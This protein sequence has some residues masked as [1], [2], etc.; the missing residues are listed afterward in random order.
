MICGGGLI[1]SVRIE[2]SSRSDSVVRDEFDS[3]FVLLPDQIKTKTKSKNF[4]P[5][6]GLWKLL[7]NYGANRNCEFWLARSSDT[8]EIIARIGA[9]IPRDRISECS[10]GFFECV[11]STD[12]RLA[13]KELIRTAVRWLAERN[14][15]AIVAPMDFNSWFS[16]RFKVRQ[17]AASTNGDDK[18]WEP[19][20]PDFHLSLF[21]DEGFDDFIQF[22][23]LSYEIA[24]PEHW[25]AY[26]RKIQPDYQAAIGQGYILRPFGTG[27]E[28][29]SDLREIFSLANIA[30]ADNPM[31]EPIPFELFSS[32]T[33]ASSQKSNMEAS[34]ICKS[35]EGQVAGFAFCFTEKDELVY[36]T[37]AV[38]PDHRSKGLAN[39]LTFEISNY[40]QEKGIRKTTGAL[41]RS[42]NRSE[43]IGQAH[44]QFA[45]PS[46][47]NSYVLLR[48]TVK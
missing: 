25:A 8:G 2:I 41:I 38:H 43:R 11:D 28:F 12:G 18:S 13:G 9:D 44:G 4:T 35:S 33:I 48:R 30:F 14:A 22:A 5:T 47:I 15:Q 26:I 1:V 23:S 37:V 16:Y 24:A 21:R 45:K 7:L 40:C 34:R 36:K 20:A 29:K 31:F 46:A 17:A 6:A 39:A 32:L 19:S 27:E 42:G 3:M 10:I